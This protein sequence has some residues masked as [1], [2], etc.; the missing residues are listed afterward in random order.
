MSAQN[1]FIAGD[2]DNTIQYALSQYNNGIEVFEFSGMT[3]LDI[4]NLYAIIL[5]EAFD[6]DKHEL[7]V[8]EVA[9][10]IDFELFELPKNLIN[11]LASLSQSE[12]KH[13]AKLW[14]ETDE[15]QWQPEQT[16]PIVQAL[17][18]LA[19]A[20]NPIFFLQEV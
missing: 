5:D 6:F 20:E 16:L 3:D 9:D 18:N 12:L 17:T 19:T 7:E 11:E 2:I 13:I 14:A 15:L 4:S 8:L 1:F 10:D